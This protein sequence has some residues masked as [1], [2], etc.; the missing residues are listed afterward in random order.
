MNKAYDGVEWDFLGAVMAKMGFVEVWIQLIMNCVKSVRFALVIN[1]KPGRY[2]S[3]SRGIHQGDPISPYL[4]I[5]INE[6]LSLLI[7]HAC[8]ANLIQGIRLAPS[9]PLLSHLL[10]AVYTLLFLKANE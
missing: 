9:G 1:D 8:N 7:N 2:F 10:F 5:M 6:V 3:P 4:F